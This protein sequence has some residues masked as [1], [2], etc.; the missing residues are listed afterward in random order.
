MM[1]RGFHHRHESLLVALIA[2]LCVVVFA[3]NPAFWSAATVF[4]VL[5]SS[6]VFA[7]F[8]LG[9]LLV[10]LSGGID[11]SFM[12]IGVFAGYSSVLLLPANDA[13]W[14]PLLAFGIAIGIGALLGLVNAAVVNG[15][16]MP[17]LIATLGTQG[18]FR[19]GLLAYVGT[20][21]IDN[22]PAG[23][24]S[25][26][27][28]DLVTTTSANG[29]IARLH[30]LIVPA[31]VLCALTAWLLRSTMLGRGIYAVGGDEES[32]RRAGLSVA[33][34]RVAV[35]G[36]AGALAGFAGLSQITLARQ[37]NPFELVGGE[38]DV[39]A[40][41]V[42]GGASINGGRGSVRATLLGVVLIALIKNSLI[43]LGVPG[44]WQRAAVG[45]LLLVAVAI[46][47]LGAAKRPPRPILE[48]E[49]AAS[50]RA[51][52]VPAGGGAP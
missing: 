9:V 16:R 3:L 49:G 32:A 39:L 15:T 1:A 11:V 40:A 50:G 45:L 20:R 23:L 38:L 30:G 8:A 19:G 25:F 2:A 48:P 51:P 29:T 21:Y 34:I 13:P 4:N 22:L 27:Q 18:I 42:I 43:L 37:A 5:R 35:F 41:V 46:Q 47:A 10:M 52:S 36:L 12:A 14:V 6:L 44:A 33:R 24:H 7:V 17:T 31:A 26:A 28:A